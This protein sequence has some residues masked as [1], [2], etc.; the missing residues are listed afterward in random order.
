MGQSLTLTRAYGWV[1]DHW[2]GEWAVEGLG[3][4]V[5]EDFS[6]HDVNDELLKANGVDCIFDS[7]GRD[8]KGLALIAR[9]SSVDS[10]DREHELDA[11]VPA[12]DA[13]A[14]E[15][16]YRAELFEALETLGW[17]H[18]PFGEPKWLVLVTYA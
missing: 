13:T 10:Y 6:Y 7:F 1:V 11:L 9:A 4:Y 15:G 16:E 14:H 18:L 2:D 3:E 17:H 5:P 12:K 8:F